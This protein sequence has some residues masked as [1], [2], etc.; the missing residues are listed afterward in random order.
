MSRNQFGRYIKRCEIVIDLKINLE[1]KYI[2]YFLKNKINL[3]FHFLTNGKI[4]TLEMEPIEVKYL[5]ITKTQGYNYQGYKFIVI[6]QKSQRCYDLHDIFISSHIY[7]KLQ[8]NLAFSFT[9]YDHYRRRLGLEM[10]SLP[11]TNCASS[12]R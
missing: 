6:N 4:L 2:I 3:C 1:N 5:I 8:I 11:R 9:A 10:T 12:P 7:N